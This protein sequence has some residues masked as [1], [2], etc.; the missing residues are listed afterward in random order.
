[1]DFGVVQLKNDGKVC[2]LNYNIVKYPV[3]EKKITG[4]YTYGTICALYRFY[5]RSV[6]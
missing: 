3:P 4:N 5:L 6:I 2:V 1:V